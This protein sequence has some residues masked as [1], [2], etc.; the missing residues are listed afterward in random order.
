MLL[1]LLEHGIP[2]HLQAV[3]QELATVSIQAHLRQIISNSLDQEHFLFVRAAF[4]DGAKNKGAKLV[5]DHQVVTFE[6]FFSE[7]KYLRMRAVLDEPLHYSATVFV[8][9]IVNDVSVDFGHETAVEI[10]L[11]DA[12]EIYEHLLNDMVAIEIERAVSDSPLCKQFLN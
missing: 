9:A 10:G 1:Q 4:K 8:H 2:Y 12:L 11:V 6:D 5:P 7:I 3:F